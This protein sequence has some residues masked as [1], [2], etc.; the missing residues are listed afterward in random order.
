MSADVLRRV[1]GQ[2]TAADPDAGARPHG[3]GWRPRPRASCSPGRGEGPV[4]V[5]GEVEVA[6]G[7]LG[8]QRQ[9]DR[10]LVRGYSEVGAGGDERHDTVQDAVHLLV[11]RALL[12][13]EKD[14]RRSQSHEDAG[15]VEHGRDGHVGGSNKPEQNCP[16]YLQPRGAGSFQVVLVGTG[17]WKVGVARLNGPRKCVVG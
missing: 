14:G 10:A 7:L 17:R 3:P 8:A 5:A 9:R 11:L 1:Q 15:D 12:G 13:D 16:V 6:R 4:D 2:P